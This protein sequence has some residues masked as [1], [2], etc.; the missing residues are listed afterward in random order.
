[1][2]ASGLFKLA[3]NREQVGILLDNLDLSMPNIKTKTLGGKLLWKNI[4]SKGG[5][6]LQQNKLFGN[7]RVIDPEN[8]RLAWGGKSKTVRAFRELLSDQS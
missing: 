7:C 8:K 2:I 3:Q 4:V 6:R 1:M 5:W